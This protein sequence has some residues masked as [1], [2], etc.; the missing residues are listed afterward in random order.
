MT[1][2]PGV[3]SQSLLHA[4]ATNAQPFGLK[5]GLKKAEEDVRRLQE[6][7]GDFKRRQEG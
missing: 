2:S 6:T 3:S 4:P 1:S 5:A 7:S